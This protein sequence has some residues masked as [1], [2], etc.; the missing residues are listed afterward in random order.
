[1]QSKRHHY[2]PETLMKP[3]LRAGN[4]MRGY[5]WDDHRNCLRYHEKGRKG[6]CAQNDL[7]TISTRDD[8]PDLI[9][10]DTF[11]RVDGRGAIAR[12]KLLD[13]GPSALDADEKHDFIRLLLSLDVRRPDVVKQL[14][15]GG[16]Y[17]R[18]KLD[19]DPEVQTLAA[20]FGLKE[21][22]SKFLEAYHGTSF[23]DRSLRLIEKLTDSS[24][25]S[26][27]VVRSKWVVRRLS[28]SA[29][30]VVLSDR[31]LVRVGGTFT[32]DFIWAL[33][34]KRDA[35][36]FATPNA[37]IAEKIRRASE[38]MVVHEVNAA[39]VAQAD[40]YVFSTI[41]HAEDGWLAKR[42]RERATNGDRA[43]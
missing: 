26:E 12:D 37:T 22:P 1:M 19:D 36:F 18:Q 3:W 2:V 15:G 32:A 10:R 25:V 39:S 7:L 17:L 9:E 34:L 6:F 20:I 42:L 5:Y 27:I 24:R 43:E 30:E 14:R 4:I 16:D 11:G 40:R 38:R 29:S 31:P 21:A 33:P 41:D 35:V 23:E 13:G 8:P 28:S